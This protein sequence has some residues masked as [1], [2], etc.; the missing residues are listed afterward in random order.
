M[1]SPV[2][3][4]RAASRWRIVPPR[5][6]GG[7]TA[8]IRRATP[9][10][11]APVDS[12]R[13]PGRPGTS[14]AIRGARTNCSSRWPG[15]P[16]WNEYGLG[17]DRARRH[18]PVLHRPTDGL[19]AQ[20]RPPLDLT[21]RAGSGGPRPQPDGL[22]RAATVQRGQWSG[23]GDPDHGHRAA[24]G[25]GAA[26]GGDVRPRLRAAARPGVPGRGGRR[27]LG[28][29]RAAGDGRGRH[30]PVR[31]PPRRRRRPGRRGHRTRTGLVD[32]LHPASAAGCGNDLARPHPPGTAAPGPDAAVQSGLGG[33]VDRGDRAR[34]RF[35]QPRVVQYR[36]PAGVR[37]D[38]AR[39][40]PRRPPAAA[41]V[42][43]PAG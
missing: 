30:P 5:G 33:A 14:G 23:P 11:C 22:A 26:L 21:D 4:E 7:S 37:H 28:S 36:V 38:A 15:P 35:R 18:G 32:P 16:G 13:S 27:R 43:R 19:R 6:P 12:R 40:P 2:C 42:R 10:P 20:R 8:S 41:W 3:T 1:R 9:S 24:G 39:G 34:L 29:L 17:R 31:P 25:A